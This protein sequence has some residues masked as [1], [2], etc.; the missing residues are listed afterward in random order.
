MPTP[1]EP[2]ALEPPSPAD[3]ATLR[4]AAAIADSPLIPPPVPGDDVTLPPAP[5][6]APQDYPAVPGYELITELGRGGMGVVYQARVLWSWGEGRCRLASHSPAAT[7]PAE[8][9]GGCE[10][11]EGQGDH[12][13]RQDKGSDSTTHLPSDSSRKEATWLRL[14]LPGVTPL[15][16]FGQKRRGREPDAIT[17]LPRNLRRWS[18]RKDGLVQNRPSLG[19]TADGVRPRRDGEFRV[20]CSGRPLLVAQRIR[21]P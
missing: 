20:P 13:A 2:S 5:E 19:N 7:A 6:G 17:L 14:V 16:R 21:Q 1:R 15:L 10:Q 12:T 9:A 8:A 4:P 18:S 3:S 11:D